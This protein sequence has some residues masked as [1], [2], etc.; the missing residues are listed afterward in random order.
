LKPAVPQG[1]AGF[2][3]GLGAGGYACQV[4]LSHHL[5]QL[6]IYQPPSHY[7][8]LQALET[9]IFLAAAFALIGATIWRVGRR[10]R[11][12]PTVGEPP[13]RTAENLAVALD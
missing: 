11:R 7:W 9:G 3:E 12:K 10:A 6:V 8:P 13:Q 1:P 2:K 4:M 5:Q